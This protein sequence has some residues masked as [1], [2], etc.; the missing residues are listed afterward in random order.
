MD[1]ELIK[2]D[3]QSGCIRLYGA[4]DFDTVAK[5]W[6]QG[7]GLVGSG[8]LGVIDLAE[9]E[10]TDSAG[11]ALLVEW[12]RVARQAGVSLM[13]RD[14]PQQMRAIIRA[15]GVEDALLM[16]EQGGSVGEGKMG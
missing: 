1:E 16:A 6:Q 9:V 7:K 13:F 2:C 14:A 12:S 8:A 10:R 15:S 5:F 11:V 4:L 3:E